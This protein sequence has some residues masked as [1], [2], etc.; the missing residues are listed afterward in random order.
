MVN[1]YIFNL[2]LKQFISFDMIWLIY[3]GLCLFHLF[4]IYTGQAQWV[5]FTLP[6]LMV[7]LMCVIIFYTKLKSY[8]SKWLLAAIFFGWLGDILLM[9]AGTIR[10]G[11]GMAAF[12]LG[13]FAYI[14][15]FSKEVSLKRK[16]H[17]LMEKTYLILPFI[18]FWFLTR[19]FLS[20]KVQ[21]FPSSPIYFYGFIILL[22]S[23]MA[24]NRWYAV[25]KLSWW[26]VW[27]GS[28]LFII[29]D[30]LLSIRLFVADFQGD[31][32]LIMGTY[33]TAQ[34]AIVYGCL[35]D[36][37]VRN[38]NRYFLRDKDIKQA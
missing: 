2:R 25:S 32:L 24:I 37:L 38:G 35:K 19:V 27:L 18:V 1:Q 13:H 15:I 17:F 8:L 12:I 4:A 23:V 9:K 30:T 16:T 29:S 11:L 6:F 3:L 34:G 20:D 10:L 31:K 28:L 21:A 36:E 33:L 22:M 5:I 26:M 7:S 14:Y